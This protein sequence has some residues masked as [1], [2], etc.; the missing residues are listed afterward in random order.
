MDSA[1]AA[2]SS[3]KQGQV[4]NTDAA[5]LDRA[6]DQLA[7]EQANVQALETKCREME[8][9]HAENLEKSKRE[10]A[11]RKMWNMEPSNVKKPIFRQYI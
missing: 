6:L 8:K 9:E 2:S 3:Q 5:K 7:H 1:E 4:E 10:Y 11:L